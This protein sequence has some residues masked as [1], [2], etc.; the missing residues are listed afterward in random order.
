ME[1]GYV[2][3][4]PKLVATA[5]GALAEFAKAFNSK[6]KPKQE[7]IEIDS[8]RFEESLADDQALMAKWCGSVQIRDMARPR[9]LDE[10]YVRLKVVE[11]ERARAS[12]TRPPAGEN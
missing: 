8:S 10:L 5:I 6:R 12:S 2:M 7:K 9:D 4:E 11:G 3:V 1:C